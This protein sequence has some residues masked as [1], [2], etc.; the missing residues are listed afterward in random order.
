MF[1]VW[2][3]SEWGSNGFQIVSEYI[4]GSIVTDT[5]DF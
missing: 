2:V 3:S 1:L 5:S 4:V